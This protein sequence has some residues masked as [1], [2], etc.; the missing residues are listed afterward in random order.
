MKKFHRS[1]SLVVAVIN[2]LPAL[3]VAEGQDKGF[4]AVKITPQMIR[5]ATVAT[6]PVERQRSRPPAAVDD[7]HLRDMFRRETRNM[8]EI[9]NGCAR[10]GGSICYD[11]RSNTTVYRPMRKLLPE[12]PG[13]TPQNLSIRRGRIVAQYTFK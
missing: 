2:L 12:I 13:L 3:A 1:L 7:D 10:D 5:E 11:Y 8:D 9:P 4:A 6:P